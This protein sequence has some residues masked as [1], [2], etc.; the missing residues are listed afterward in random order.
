[1][2]IRPINEQQITSADV[3][4]KDEPSGLSSRR[5][6]RAWITGCLGVLVLGS[7]GCGSV[8]TGVD[9]MINDAQECLDESMV[10]Y[11]N[12]ALAE[13]AWIR[14]RH[15]YI[16]QQYHRD[17]KDGFISGY[18]GV[19]AG[20]NGCTPAIAPSQYWGWKY[21]SS[22]GQAAVNAWFEGY[23][24]GAKAAE[25]DGVGNWQSIRM[26]LRKPAEINMTESDL[27][28][29]PGNAVPFLDQPENLPAPREESQL[30]EPQLDVSPAERP[31]D[32]D[33]D[34]NEVEIVDPESVYQQPSSNGRQNAVSDVSASIADLEVATSRNAAPTSDLLVP[35]NGT[36]EFS[37]AFVN[38][39]F[40]PPASSDASLEADE[41]PFNFE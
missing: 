29:A 5:R 33:I 25:Q 26:H 30:F 19:A 10:D 4:E 17:F 2:A 12:R 23:P 15:R 22:Y 24:F 14:V 40:A 31:W 8:T 32:E 36:H 1:M 39:L 38:D 41:L 11:R 21:Q 18:M 28:M 6:R 37:D 35:D 16:H 13:K 20:G 9:R 3:V 27:G 7:T 34:F